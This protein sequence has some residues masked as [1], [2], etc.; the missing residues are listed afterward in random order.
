MIALHMRANGYSP[1]AVLSAIRE[2]APTIRTGTDKRRNW[3]AYAERT[4]NYA[5]GFAGDRDLMKNER[6]RKLWLK[7]EDRVSN[8]I[9]LRNFHQLPKL[10][11]QIKQL[12]IGIF[13]PLTRN[14]DLEQG[15]KS[16]DNLRLPYGYCTRFLYIF[17]DL[18]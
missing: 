10:S 7:I 4:T 14:S 2:C 17:E 9:N 16:D 3:D 15:L 5:F 8:K 11:I 6:Y 18:L 1:N 13:H 12:G